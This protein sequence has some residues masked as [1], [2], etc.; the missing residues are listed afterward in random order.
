MPV[1]RKLTVQLKTS[2]FHQGL[3][4]LLA[5]V[6]L[7]GMFY[8]GPGFVVFV[9]AA[10]IIAVIWAW[11]VNRIN[12]RRWRKL[13]IAPDRHLTL[14]DR[15]GHAYPGRLKGRARSTP[16]FTWITIRLDEGMT[17]RLCLF[18]DSASDLNLGQIRAALEKSAADSG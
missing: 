13:L 12:Q 4:T 7:A 16:L 6:A 17:R 14:V 9:V 18:P 1:K 3:V 10:L 15:H 2:L 5:M 11:Q 8:A